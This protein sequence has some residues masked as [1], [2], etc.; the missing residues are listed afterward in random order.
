[1]ARKD[2]QVHVKLFPEDMKFVLGFILFVCIYVLVGV[3]LRGLSQ[4]GFESPPIE[5]LIVNRRWRVQSC[6]RSGHLKREKG[7]EKTRV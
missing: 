6:F 5:D 7:R 4:K 2:L 1:M 3:Q